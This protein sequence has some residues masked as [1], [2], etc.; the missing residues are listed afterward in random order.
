M[1]DPVSQSESTVLLVLAQLSAGL[2]FFAFGIDRELMKTLITSIQTLP[3]GSFRITSQIVDHWI[4]LLGWI[5]TT[6]LRVAMPVIILLVLIDLAFGILS[7]VNAQIH[8][9]SLLLSGKILITLAVIGSV[10]TLF[11]IIYSPLAGRVLS[12][13]RAAA[14]IP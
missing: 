4:T 9:T 1:I 12:A 11:P 14:G 3:P 8:V 5:F 2:L 10:A 6:G 7:R 13:V